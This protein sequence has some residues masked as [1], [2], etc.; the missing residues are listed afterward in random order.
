VTAAGLLAVINILMPQ[1]LCETFADE[2]MWRCGGVV[3]HMNDESHFCWLR[4]STFS[5][6]SGVVYPLL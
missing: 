6:G 1:D 5:Y 4:R 3:M 2:S